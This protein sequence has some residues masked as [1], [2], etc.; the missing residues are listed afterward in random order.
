MTNSSP[1]PEPTL[2]S[3]FS[4]LLKFIYP[5]LCQV[6]GAAFDGDNIWLCHR[7][8]SIL[9]QRPAPVC[10]I[11]R[12]LQDKPISR[13]HHCRKRTLIKWVY[14]LGT[15]DGPY[16]NLIKAFKYSPKPG[17]GKLLGEMLANKLK[18]FKH[19]KNID[20]ICPVPLHYRK[21]VRRGFNQSEVI[22]R[23][24][25]E[26][27]QLEYLPGQLIQV[28]QNRD[29][30]GLTIAERF[31]NVHDIYEVSRDFDLAGKSVLLVDDVTTSGAT[32]HAAARALRDGG[33]NSV[34]AAT[35]AVATEAGID[36]AATL[37]YLTEVF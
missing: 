29:Q 23:Q 33:V 31:A 1:P 11:C 3:L 21:Q 30:I 19:L 12:H 15:Y 14:S 2:R 9:E 10:P 27:L 8:R 24:L 6:C 20:A 28:R 26:S 25:A 35:I 36:P 17:L 22:A 16:G 18:E 32:L 7:C 34:A 37:D 13:C 5:P 4:D